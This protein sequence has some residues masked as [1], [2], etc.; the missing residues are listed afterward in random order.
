MALVNE[1]IFFVIRVIDQCLIH[2]TA[3]VILLLNFSEPLDYMYFPGLAFD[4]VFRHCFRVLNSIGNLNHGMRL[5]FFKRGGG[6]PNWNWRDLLL[7][8]K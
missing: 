2:T 8:C 1:G 7:Q 6:S 5:I 4:M 3:S